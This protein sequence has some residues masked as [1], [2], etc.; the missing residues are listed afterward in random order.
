MIPQPETHYRVMSCERIIGIFFRRAWRIK[1]K[2]SKGQTFNFED[3][4]RERGG[5]TEKKTSSSSWWENPAWN[6]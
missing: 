6:I 4:E 1:G 3:R 2:K 5:E